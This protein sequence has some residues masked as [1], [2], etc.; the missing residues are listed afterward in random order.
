MGLAFGTAVGSLLIFQNNSLNPFAC[1]LR[2]FVMSIAFEFGRFTG[3]TSAEMDPSP[4]NY[5]EHPADV[6]MRTI[7]VYCTTFQV[8]WNASLNGI[9]RFIFLRAWEDAFSF[10]VLVLTECFWLAVALV[11]GVFLKIRISYASIHLIMYCM[12]DEAVH[13]QSFIQQNRRGLPPT[14]RIRKDACWFAARWDCKNVLNHLS[15][16]WANLNIID[17]SCHPCSLGGQAADHWRVREARQILPSCDAV[18]VVQAGPSSQV[19]SALD[20][21][22]LTRRQIVGYICVS[23]SLL[24]FRERSILNQ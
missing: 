19:V 8:L 5:S 24:Q 1:Y 22:D 6:V 7:F 15:R 14:S 3:L 20:W 11:V 2:S 12:Q 21:W 18:P 13:E 9:L 17:S 10:L 16:H 4:W 23:H